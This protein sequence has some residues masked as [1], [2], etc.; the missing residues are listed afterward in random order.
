MLRRGAA[1]RAVGGVVIALLGAAVALVATWSVVTPWN[2]PVWPLLAFVPVPALVW[3]V[4]VGIPSRVR[5][6][7]AAAVA[8]VVV[9][10]VAVWASP[11]PGGV[12]YGDTLD[13]L[14]E[15][16]VAVLADAPTPTEA[17]G[18]PPPMDYGV[19]GVPTE[20]CVVTYA[21]G[22]VNAAVGSVPETEV[23][24]VR[25]DWTA[26]SA[27]V[28]RSLVFEGSVPQPPAGRCV[29]QVES[30]WWAWSLPDGGCPRGFAAS[31]D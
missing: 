20:V 4:I 9:A 14:E 1:S 23:R 22:V 28:A 13:D 26:G 5:L 15:V 16:A 17:C 2:L 21:L 10:T 8:L 19:L 11:L 24:Q 12:R 27:V 3:W 7:T 29:R 6:V 25:F 31:S 30:R 18:S